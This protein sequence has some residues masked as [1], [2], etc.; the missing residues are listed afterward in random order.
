MIKIFDDFKYLDKYKDDWPVLAASLKIPTVEYQWFKESLIAF[1]QNDEINIVCILKESSLSAAAFLF[2]SKAAQNNHYL[3][4]FSS[5]YLFEPSGL[6]Y[7]DKSAL[8][9]LLDALKNIGIPLLL[10]RVP[11]SLIQSAGICR[12]HSK[13]LWFVLPD[14]GSQFIN[15]SGDFNTFERM[16]SSRRRYDLKRATNNSKSRGEIEYRIFKPDHMKIG[17][18]LDQAFDI[19]DRS[20]KGEKGSSINKKPELSICF[21]NYLSALSREGKVIV[22]FMDINKRSISCVISILEYDRIWILKT[23]YDPEYRECSPGILLIHQLIKYA[24]DHKLSGI[25]FLVYK[26][27]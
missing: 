22:G 13:G 9:D 25:E 20:W 4:L 10:S 15:I 18:I 1:H 6:L 27:N 24:F 26:R 23:G 7:K 11:V 5:N 3:Q 21:R 12:W 8:L 19:E 16:L 17:Q 14:T 2:R